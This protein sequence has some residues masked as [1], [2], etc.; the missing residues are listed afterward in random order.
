MSALTARCDWR[1]AEEDRTASQALADRIGVPHIVAHILRTRGAASVEDAERFLNPSLDYLSAPSLLDD[2][3]RAVERISAARKNNERVLV[4]GDY[5]VDGIAGAALMLRALR[6]FGI[7]QSTHA[8]PKRLTEGYGIGIDHIDQARA[9]GV[10]LIITV[11]NGIAAHE[12]I[13]RAQ[14]LGIDVIVTDHHQIDGPLPKA[15][16][17]MNPKRQASGYPGVD[18]CGAGVAFRL[19]WALT[20]EQADLDLVALATVA[21]IVPLRGENRD[22]VAVGLAALA[23][24]PR[25]GLIQLAK[26]AGIDLKK[27]TAEDLS[28][29]LAPRINAGG[30]M[31]DGLAGLNL[32]LTDS[33][34]EAAELAEEL[35]AANQERKEHEQATYNEA[36][37]MIESGYTESQRSIVLARRGWHPG[38]VGIV[39]SRIQS[40][41]YRP[42]VL[43]AINGD[44]LGRGS[45]RSV[46]GLNIAEALKACETHL[47]ACGGH[48]AAAGIT[49]EETKVEAFQNAFESEAASRL[50]AHDLKRPLS[51]DAQVALTEIDGKL[52][53]LLD[54]LQP[55]GAANPSPVLAA[56]G[57][58]VARQSC[59]ELRGGHL[60]F[61]VTDGTRTFDTIGFRMGDRLSALQSVDAIDVAFNPQFNTWRGETVVQL[62]VKDI[63]AAQ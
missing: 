31:G 34:V 39:A 49:I 23:R 13:E 20:G 27:V 26:V 60:K 15:F 57:V 38:V 9:E 3:D 10:S 46:D 41:Y 30:R 52:V 51:I 42:V 48:A 56:Y 32:L 58:R 47:V 21:D 62:V 1:V 14:S 43:V 59:R 28:F 22:L 12:P 7:E 36:L 29:Q 11:D 5:D 37:E 8:M 4:F 45:A 16:A 24:A 17:V 19:A 54:R 18:S 44:G 61:A 55:C 63:R 6:R 25:T 35:D 40:R 2:L 53:T 33:A 50:P